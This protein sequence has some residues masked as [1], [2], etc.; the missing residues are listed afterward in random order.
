MKHHCRILPLGLVFVFL[1]ATHFMT[2]QEPNSPSS[3]ESS[4][5]I[6]FNRDIV[7]I[8]TQRCLE[9]HGPDE[10][11]NDFRVDDKDS[12]MGYVSAGDLATSAIWTD[13]LITWDAEQKMPPAAK[14]QL[15]G[16]ELAAIKLWIEEGATWAPPVDT[17]D[18][19]TAAPPATP[20]LLRRVATF[21]GL[22][23]PA[24]VHLPIA[25]LLVSFLFLVGS[26]YNRTAFESAAFH[27]LWIGA[28]GAVM[29]CTLGWFYAES[30]GYGGPLFDFSDGSQRHRWSGV[31]TAILALG[32]VPFARQSRK[33]DRIQGSRLVWLIGAFILA[34]LVSIVG[35]QGGELHYGERVFSDAY[36]A[37]FNP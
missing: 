34:T 2:A 36:N 14:P 27:C 30:K 21:L 29:S 17:S 13:Y 1:F 6:D 19:K 31:L 15:T 22:F 28:I 12:L 35:H 32:L 26:C 16:T 4:N 37:I 9:C 24:A 3:I 10:A 5:L 23:H 7:P 33:L 8:L 20:P 11:K 25:L 18:T